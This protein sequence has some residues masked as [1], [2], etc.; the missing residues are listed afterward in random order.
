MRS[1]PERIRLIAVDMDGT[2]L[3]DRGHITQATLDVIAAA[4]AQG[5]VFAICTGRFFEN[6]SILISDAGL[7]CPI[8]GVNGAVIGDKPFGKLLREHLMDRKLALEA[9]HILEEQQALYY[10]FSPQLVATRYP[11]DQHH[12][13]RD[14]GERMTKEGGTRYTYGR[15]ACLEAI[16]GGIYK[17]YVHSEGDL[18]ALRRHREGLEP[19]EGIAITQSSELNIELMPLDVDKGS[20]IRDLA[21]LYGI[22]MEE[23]MAIGDQDNDLPMLRAAGW[24]VA[25]DNAKPDIKA[26]ADAVTASNNE[27]GVARAIWRYALPDSVSGQA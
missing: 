22:P 25:M 13:L 6:A 12:S 5:I 4:Q 14:F 16:E 1:A 9:F 24:G 23:V 15:E 2:L 3:N 21:E 18:A 10:V 11:D 8:I 7:R 19:L 17:Y 27:D 26:E 20:G